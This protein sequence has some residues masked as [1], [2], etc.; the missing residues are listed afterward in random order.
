MKHGK[1]INIKTENSGTMRSQLMVVLSQIENAEMVNSMIAS[2]KEK[3][4]LTKHTRAIS[5]VKSGVKEGKYRT[6]IGMPRKPIE[7]ANYT[8]MINKLYSYYM[9]QEIS[10]STF[11]Q[12]VEWLI[13]ETKL[14]NGVLDSTLYR[15]RKTVERFTDDTLMS[16]KLSEVTED[17]I[18]SS[19]RSR[20]EE[21]SRRR[22]K[23]P[24]LSDVGAYLR[25]VHNIFRIAI[26]KG[27]VTFDPSANMKRQ[28]FKTSCNPKSRRPEDN[29]LS[30]G[31]IDK[32]NRAFLADSKS[33]L[34]LAG[35]ISIWSGMREGE[36][37]AVTWEDVGENY[38]HVHRQQ[39]WK[40]NAQGKR[41]ELVVVPWTKNEK[42]VPQGGRMIPMIKELR[43]AVQDARR[44]QVERGIYRRDGFVIC[45]EDG[46]PMIKDSYAQYLNRTCRK[47]S[48]PVTNNHSLRKS[49]NS[50]VLISRFGLDLRE[51][52]KV[53][54]HSEEV[55]ERN[56]TYT[57]DSVYAGIT[58]K[59]LEVESSLR[60]EGDRMSGM[61]GAEVVR[62][63]ARPRRAI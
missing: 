31:N 23:K 18:Y 42:G 3:W 25:H 41:S 33:Y 38:I 30:P 6:Y 46:S 9:D 57:D 7:A 52:A 8:T 55:N 59:I 56:Y 45:T 26:S 53:M 50:N 14:R 4:V 22:N 43:S 19:M 36:L 54:G 37:P 40:E 32:L 27:V 58:D 62:R 29:V 48:L 10:A 2:A 35:R 11:G 49:Y 47:L 28:D 39:L 13:E 51:R 60:G 44:W 34:A 24:A 63:I 17:Q 20:I 21:I 12:A 15:I 1:P 5:R 16:T 61:A